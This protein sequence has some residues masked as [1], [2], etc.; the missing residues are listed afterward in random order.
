[1]F[2]LEIIILFMILLLIFG[3]SQ[4]FSGELRFE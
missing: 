4:G 1:M 3:D 2:A